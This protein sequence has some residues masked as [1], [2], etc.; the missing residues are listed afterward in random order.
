MFFL[1]GKCEW[2]ISIWAEWKKKREE[3]R[4][5]CWTSGPVTGSGRGVMKNAW[6]AAASRE[7]SQGR[8]LQ[9]MQGKYTPVMRAILKSALR[10]AIPLSRSAILL[11]SPSTLLLNLP[12]RAGGGVGWGWGGGAQSTPS[13]CTPIFVHFQPRCYCRAFQQLCD[14]R[15]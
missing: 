4:P 6:A 14:I 2:G 10:G 12:L 7:M 1:C 9:L 8:W 11:L 3:Q 13:S 15:N 5:V